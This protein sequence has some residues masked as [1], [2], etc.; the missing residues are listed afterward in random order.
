MEILLR[1]LVKILVNVGLLFLCPGFY[2]LGDCL[3][4]PVSK[5]YYCC[6]V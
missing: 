4:C 3:L 1:L 6:G 2:S 5:M